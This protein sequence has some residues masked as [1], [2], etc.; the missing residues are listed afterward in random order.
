MSREFNI[1][2][3][4]REVA[5]KH[6]EAYD[7][8]DWNT[9]QQQ[10]KAGGLQAKPSMVI[11]V[12]KYMVKFVTTA[13]MVYVLPASNSLNQGQ[14]AE[15]EI[16]AS[17]SKTGHQK[18]LLKNEVEKN[19]GSIT[20]VKVPNKVHSSKTPSLFSDK[21]FLDKSVKLPEAFEQSKVRSKTGKRSSD[22]KAFNKK[23]GNPTSRKKPIPAI[24]QGS[25]HPKVVKNKVVPIGK[26]PAHTLGRNA[27]TLIKNAPLAVKKP[28]K[29]T[30]LNYKQLGKNSK[31]N[32]P[33]VQN[34]KLPSLPAVKNKQLKNTNHQSSVVTT[35][36]GGT[37]KKNIQPQ[38]VRVSHQEMSH[39]AATSFTL[40]KISTE[41]TQGYLPL[42]LDSIVLNTQQVSAK[43]HQQS[44]EWSQRPRNIFEKAGRWIGVLPHPKKAAQ[45]L[46]RQT[47]RQK[48]RVTK[49]SLAKLAWATK[50]LPPVKDSL[51]ASPLKIKNKNKFL[52]ITIPKVKLGPLLNKFFGK[53]EGDTTALAKEAKKDTTPSKYPIRQ[54]HIGFVYPLSSNGT[55]AYEYSNR[56]SVHALIGSAAALDGTEFAGFGNIEKDYVKGAQFAGFF[57]TVG[58]QVTGMQAAGFF[59]NVGGNLV[60]AQLAGFLNM[61]GIKKSNTSRLATQKFSM[62]AAGFGNLNFSRALNFQGAGFFNV[63]RRIDGVQGAGFVNIGQ[64]INGFQGSGFVGL[65]QKIRGAQIS[66]FLN[67]AEQVEGLQMAG[68]VNISGKVKGTQIGI[69]NIAD[70][71]SGGVPIGFLSIVRNGYRKLSVWGG[72]SLHANV[73]Y[74][75]GVRKFYN[76]FAVGGQFLP[77]QF[78]WGIGYGIGT[79]RDFNAKNNLS[80][81]LM[82]YHINENTFWEEKMRLL[83]QF[84]ILYGRDFKNGLSLYIGPAFNVLVSQDTPE[85]G[86]LASKL[87]PFQFY[88]NTINGT[89]V[90]IWTGFQLGLRF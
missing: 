42:Y 77:N 58:K 36:K 37:L 85:T 73:G 28:H 53:K 30:N 84:K 43:A 63:G 59:N 6:E 80:L 10:L 4:F 13:M 60:G 33:V 75:I 51:T 87:P 39:I 3:I 32:P 86:V 62:Q 70:S 78:R 57:N 82:G 83:N 1:D 47:A 61:A 31:S 81:E 38:Q 46:A 15:A 2:K 90:K 72:E 50:K 24:R 11:Q 21:N 41:I 22:K 34:K 14:V 17:S 12:I 66:G 23:T 19:D 7:P 88:N 48:Q 69:L 65:A 49:D 64:E 56:L 52:G 29:P 5:N 40:A 25:T 76:I 26:Q 35:S 18:Q 79:I 16:I 68:F 44:M 74:K 20:S 45:K 71:I 67:V 55:Q 89:N 9:F 27:N 8:Q 54:A